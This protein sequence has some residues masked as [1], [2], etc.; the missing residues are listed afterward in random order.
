MAQLWLL[1]AML[2]VKKLSERCMETCTSWWHLCCLAAPA[3]L[4]PAPCLPQTHPTGTQVLPNGSRRPRGLPLSEKLLPGERWQEAVVRGV[5]EEL[6]PVL[7]ANPQVGTVQPVAEAG[8]T[9]SIAR[10]VMREGDIMTCPA[11]LPERAYHRPAREAPM[12]QPA[13]PA[14][15]CRWRWMRRRCRRA[16][17]PRRA[18]ATP[19]CCPR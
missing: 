13:L 7:P 2:M 14:M 18:R 5:V 6:G 15:P 11:A 4:T 19:A 1:A 16:W 8:C 12:L 9:A 10:S 17:R 3:R